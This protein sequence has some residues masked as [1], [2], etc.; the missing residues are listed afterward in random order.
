MNIKFR[1]LPIFLSS[2]IL[3]VCSCLHSSHKNP[4][5]DTFYTEKGE[6]DSARLP[7]VKPYEA[8]I[9]S[10]DLGWSMNLKG[11]DGDTGFQNIKKANVVNG[12]ILLY[13]INSILHGVDVKQS[14][15]IIIPAKQI[16]KGF[17]NHQGYIDYLKNMGVKVEPELHN[18]DLIANYFED[19]DTIDWKAIN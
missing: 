16:E 2:L 13:G 4:N 7:F 12:V 10:K 5:T 6:W 14:W 17:A 9:I 8:V 18:I 19:H 1:R 15:H 11:L 3:L